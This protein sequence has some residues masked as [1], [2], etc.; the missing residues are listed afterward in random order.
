MTPCHVDATSA[1]GCLVTTRGTVVR[2]VP[3]LPKAK[4][5]SGTVKWTVTRTRTLGHTL[6]HSHLHSH[7]NTHSTRTFAPSLT[8]GEGGRTTAEPW[9]RSPVDPAPCRFSRPWMEVAAGV[10]PSG[11]ESCGDK[12]VAAVSS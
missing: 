1:A 12:R 6:F 4:A 11:W 8:R 2:S 3:I 5:A 9:G 7:T 10:R